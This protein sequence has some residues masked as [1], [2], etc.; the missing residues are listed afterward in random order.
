[1]AETL[2]YSSGNTITPNAYAFTTARPTTMTLLATSTYTGADYDSP[3]SQWI[4]G[5]L[6]GAPSSVY[7]MI[8]CE[9][10]LSLSYDDARIQYEAQHRGS[11]I[12]GI[13]CGSLASIIL[14]AMVIWVVWRRRRRVEGGR[15]SSVTTEKA[16]SNSSAGETKS[17]GRSIYDQFQ[18][19][20]DN[21]D[22][23]NFNSE[24][25]KQ[26]TV[27]VP[28]DGLVREGAED[29]WPSA[30]CGPQRRS[31]EGGV[32]AGDTIRSMSARMENVPAW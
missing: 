3:C 1:M 5:S 31:E 27:S 28:G 29:A 7:L 10:D 30:A 25:M 23:A 22:S 13:V 26:D 4:A 14:L 18:A 8:V 12:I 32:V 17:H 11:T 21:L 15:K 9:T 24:I 2:T 19:R 16:V 6:E 20:L